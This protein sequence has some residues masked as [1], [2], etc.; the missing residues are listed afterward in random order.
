LLEQ[1]ADTTRKPALR[2]R[3]AR[4]RGQVMLWSGD[5]AAA[6]TLLLDEAARLDGDDR[7][8][9]APLLADA[10]TAFILLDE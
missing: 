8:R 4:R 6:A 1:A 7:Q 3:A 10:A 5:V 2:A 9:A